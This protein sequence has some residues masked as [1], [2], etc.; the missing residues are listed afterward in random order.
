MGFIYGAYT[1]QHEL[2][3]CATADSIA[4]TVTIFQYGAG[5]SGVFRTLGKYMSASGGMF[6]YVV[7]HPLF[8]PTILTSDSVFMGIG[9]VIR[10]DEQQRAAQL[11]RAQYRYPLVVHPRPDRNQAPVRQ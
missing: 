6:A 3:A 11:W 9:S 8:L 4:G 7:L 2:N 1:Y 10:H 5:T